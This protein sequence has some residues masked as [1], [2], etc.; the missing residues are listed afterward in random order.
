[1]SRNALFASIN[2]NNLIDTEFN[3]CVAGDGDNKI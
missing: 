3:M 2:T 1:M